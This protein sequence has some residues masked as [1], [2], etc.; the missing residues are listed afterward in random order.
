MKHDFSEDE[1]IFELKGKYFV[2][3]VAHLIK[4]GSAYALSNRDINEL[5]VIK[6]DNVHT[7]PEK[8]QSDYNKYRDRTTKRIRLATKTL[9]EDYSGELLKTDAGGYYWLDT[10]TRNIALDLNTHMTVTRAML[11]ALVKDNL[12]NLLPPSELNNLTPYFDKA[13]KTLSKFRLSQKN[14][15]TAADYKPFSMNFIPKAVDQTT[16]EKIFAAIEAKKVIKAKYNSIHGG[17]PEEIV[18]SPQKIIMQFQQTQV[19][20]FVHNADASGGTSSDINT[21]TN[22]KNIHRHLTMNNFSDVEIIKSQYND[23]QQPKKTFTLI[24]YAHEWA[25]KNLAN[26]LISEDQEITP[27]AKMTEDE[28]KQCQSVRKKEPEKWSKVTATIELPKAFLDFQGEWDAWFFV[29][30]ISMYGS[31]LLVVEPTIVVNEIKR[32]VDGF[33]DAYNNKRSC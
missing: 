33:N 11:Y 9:F 8:I 14:K 24:A 15:I 10:D 3:A 19:V 16:H 23:T 20:G 13:E 17:M 18:F 31:D 21:H 28:K 29:N 27:W 4:A 5:H 22:S 12:I 32:R 25:T 2:N 6:I 30:A 26:L 1:G 7:L